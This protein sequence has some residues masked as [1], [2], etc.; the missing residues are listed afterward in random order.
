[1]K[2]NKLKTISIK[3]NLQEHF[4]NMYVCM[5]S[6]PNCRYVKEFLYESKKVEVIKVVKKRVVNTYYIKNLSEEE[7]ETL[8]KI[9]ADVLS[10]NRQISLNK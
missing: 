5:K 2:T 3:S 4:E 8:E 1:M 9:K 7:R 6:R 10:W